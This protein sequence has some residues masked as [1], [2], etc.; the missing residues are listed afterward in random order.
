[1]RIFRL[2][3]GDEEI[4]MNI[5]KKF[6]LKKPESHEIAD[7]LADNNNIIIVAQLEKMTIGFLLAYQLS[8]L[9]GGNPMVFIY[10]VEVLEKYR[11]NDVARSMLNELRNEFNPNECKKIFV[12]TDTDNEAA[13]NLYKST[14]GT[15]HKKDFALFEWLLS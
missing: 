1:M 6:K 12:I 11:R 5:A 10:E 3:S 2:K 14:V 9:D 8:R 15:R 4:A 7:F 13:I